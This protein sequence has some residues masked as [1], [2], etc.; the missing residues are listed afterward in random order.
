[1]ASKTRNIII[2]CIFI[3]IALFGIGLVVGYINGET[4][5]KR[6]RSTAINDSS[7]GACSDTKWSEKET[8]LVM[9]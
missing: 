3:S 7:A 8:R 2:T 1:M 9:I 6:H 4:A 5:A